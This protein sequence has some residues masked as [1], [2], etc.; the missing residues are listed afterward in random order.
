[1]IVE[2]N[3]R[4]QYNITQKITSQEKSQKINIKISLSSPAALDLST[5]GR[6]AAPRLYRALSPGLPGA[7]PQKDE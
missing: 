7:P 2:E 3:Y 1:M 5:P 6:E 4:L